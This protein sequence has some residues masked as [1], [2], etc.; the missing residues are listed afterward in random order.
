MSLAALLAGLYHQD[1]QPLNLAEQESGLLAC[2]LRQKMRRGGQLGK[3]VLPIMPM[4]H[5][6]SEQRVG[7]DGKL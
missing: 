6:K 2:C 1:C 4:C 3:F 7:E 5:L